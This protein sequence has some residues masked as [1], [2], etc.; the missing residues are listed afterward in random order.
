MSLRYVTKLTGATVMLA[1]GATVALAQ[2]KP[3]S[4]KRIP[5]SKEGSAGGEV[6][7]RVDTVTVYRTDTLR[8][9]TPGTVD[10]VR[11]TNTITRVDTVMMAPAMRPIHLPYGMYFGV[12]G[13]FS[14]PNGALFNPN[15]TGPSAQAQ[16][17]WQ[18]HILGLRGDVNY[19]RPMQ[20]AAFANPNEA[21]ILNFSADAKLNIP[22]LTHVF[23]SSHRFGLY[24]IGGYTH[25][26][27]KD[28]PMRID[29]DITGANLQFTQ[30]VDSWTHENGWN[31]GGGASLSWGRTELFLESRALVFTAPNAAQSRQIPFVF[32][33]NVY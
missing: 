10:T 31:A 6:L 12:A 30:P 21:K 32:G 13:G 2:S 17:G 8:L 1:V 4:T 5:I 24:G 3:T 14:S 7:S 16:L 27:F 19:A 28:L 29:T 26:M 22:F 18:G 23:G 15:N 9:T 33:I 11:L 25:T 20:D